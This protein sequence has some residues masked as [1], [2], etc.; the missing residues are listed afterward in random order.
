[1]KNNPKI[2]AFEDLIAWKKGQDLAVLVYNEFKNSKDY[3]FKDQICRASVSVS[4]NIAEGFDRNTKKEFSRF[5]YIAKGSCAEVRSMMYLAIRLDYSSTETTTR[6][7]NLTEE[8]AKIIRGLL[9]VL[10]TEN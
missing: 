8:I 6:I 7:Q 10:N 3:G 5:L 9:K 4:N 2:T 1:M